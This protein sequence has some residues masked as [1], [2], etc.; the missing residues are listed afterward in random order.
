MRGQI[1]D[2]VILVTK[3]YIGSDDE[4]SLHLNSFLW[5]LLL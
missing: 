4:L 5:G 3:G 1:F 2:V